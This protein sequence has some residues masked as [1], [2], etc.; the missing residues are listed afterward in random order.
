M[1]SSPPQTSDSPPAPVKHPDTSPVPVGPT[2]SRQST[3]ALVAIARALLTMAEV[4]PAQPHPT[5]RAAAN[6]HWLNTDPPTP[7]P[8]DQ[9]LVQAPQGQLLLDQRPQ[10]VE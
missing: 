4:R 3:P 8:V 1:L 10:M 2:T 9:A 7:A 5:T 6:H